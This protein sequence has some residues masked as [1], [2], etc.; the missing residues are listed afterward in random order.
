MPLNISKQQILDFLSVSNCAQNRTTMNWTQI[1]ICII[2][3]F[4]TI[5]IVYR[6]ITVSLKL[7]EYES[8]KKNSKKEA[9]KMSAYFHFVFMYRYGRYTTG[10]G[11]M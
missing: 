10:C 4:N 1:E 8:T 11:E 3:C 9:K 2:N 7:I 5:C 6:F